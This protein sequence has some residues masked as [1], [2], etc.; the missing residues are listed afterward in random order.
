MSTPFLNEHI[1]GSRTGQ[2]SGTQMIEI[3]A[4][5][6]TDVQGYMV[7]GYRGT[8]SLLQQ[9]LTQTIGLVTR[10][11]PKT[12]I[13][14]PESGVV[15]VGLDFYF[16][17]A[18]QALA[19]LER[20]GVTIIEF[21]YFGTYAGPAPTAGPAAGVAPT[22]VPGAPATGQS[23]QR[24]GTGL[25]PADFTWTVAT[26]SPNAVNAGQ[27]FVWPEPEPEPDPDPEEPPV[28]PAPT[29]PVAVALVDRVVAFLGQNG[30]DGFAASAVE[31][32]SV[33]TEMAYA[34]TRGKGFIN[35]EPAGA[36]ASAIVSA[37]AR[38]LANPEQLEYQ[39]GSIAIRSAFDGWSPLE[40]TL[41]GTLRGRAR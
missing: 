38:L 7:A 27:T 11:N 36:V 14:V 10:D 9:G 15:R 29:L 40:K 8:S 24:I 1:V 13:I 28:D 32:V 18:P 34:Y 37:S 31:H 30:N 5:P 17:S 2:F 6:G 20:D 25:V 23:F 35:G 19:L 41:L 39:T 12:P 16:S 3:A 33:I 21:L 22:V 4:E 26:S